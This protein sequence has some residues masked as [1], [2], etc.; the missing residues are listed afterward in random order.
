MRFVEISSHNEMFGLKWQN[1]F[2]FKIERGVT[3]N[4]VCVLELYIHGQ[5]TKARK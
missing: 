1:V 3:G 2:L 5:C 4:A